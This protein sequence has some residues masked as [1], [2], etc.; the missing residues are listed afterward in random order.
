MK[1]E[2]YRKSSDFKRKQIEFEKGNI[3]IKGE[4]DHWDAFAYIMRKAPEII[5][6]I[7]EDT[8]LYEEILSKAL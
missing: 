7:N 8:S 1:I 3:T 4:W 6:L 5:A 2:E